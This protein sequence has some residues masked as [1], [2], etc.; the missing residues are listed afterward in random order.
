MII[1]DLL[2]PNMEIRHLENISGAEKATGMAVIID[3]FRAFSTA[4]YLYDRGA[5][6]IYVTGDVA[7]AFA[8][9][10][11]HPATLLV[12]ERKEKKVEGFDHGNSPS[13]VLAEDLRGREVVLTTSA[14]TQGL[15]RARHAGR[16]LAASFVNAPATA[17]FLRQE[18]PPVVSL[19]AMGYNALT[20][21]DED[22]L[23]ADYIHALLE[24]K[25]P[26]FPA[27][28]H[29]I[30]QGTGARFFD[31]DNLNSPE[32][33]YHLCLMP[34]RFPYVLEA[35]PAERNGLLLL[36]KITL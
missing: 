17:A 11:N 5:E 6:R 23:C 26:D 7:Q 14:G 25:K 22:L 27:M 20:P 30:R 34:G 2:L 19:V 4:C 16:V 9:R 8:Y 33:D 24:H 29:Q 36:K 13:S 31:P 10:R 35:V 15:V 18:K 21:A 28:E 3:V 12:G 1:F 32:E